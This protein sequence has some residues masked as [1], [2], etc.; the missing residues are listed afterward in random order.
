MN[1]RNYKIYLLICH[2]KKPKIT[3]DR[4]N[5]FVLCAEK[6]FSGNVGLYKL[7]IQILNFEKK[8]L[9]SFRF[10]NALNPEVPNS[11][12]NY[13]IIIKKSKIYV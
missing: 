11:G 9:T 8:Y 4:E 3:I 2:C 6:K 13:E 7:C 10:F 5:V 1:E 12:R